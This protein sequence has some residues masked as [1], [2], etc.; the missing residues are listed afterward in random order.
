MELDTHF[1]EAVCFI[2]FIALI[3]KPAKNFIVN[4]LKDHSQNIH[5][6]IKDSEDLRIESEKTIEFYRNQSDTFNKQVDLIYKNTEDNIKKIMDLSTK[7]TE[8]KI[9]A[10]TDLHKEKLSIYEM[11]QTNKIKLEAVT[12]ALVV[13]QNYLNDHKQHAVNQKQIDE[14]LNITK[15]QKI[16]LH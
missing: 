15:N 7:Q 11:E 8:E 16:I 6:K 10:K 12:K 2:G 14:T 4:Y 3:Y 1:W 13:V 9:K 5:D